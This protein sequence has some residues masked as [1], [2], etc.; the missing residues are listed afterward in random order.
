M[1]FHQVPVNAHG[2]AWHLGLTLVLLAS[3]TQQ[4][5]VTFKATEA[6]GQLI[7]GS[8][9]P[10]THFLVNLFGYHWLRLHG[11]ARRGAEGRGGG[12]REKWEGGAMERQPQRVR[13]SW[14][15]KEDDREG[16]ERKRRR[17]K[18]SGGGGE[19]ETQKRSCVS[20]TLSWT[21]WVLGCLPLPTPKAARTIIACVLSL[22]PQ[23]S[24]L[25]GS[26]SVTTIIC[27]G[28]PSC[29]GWVA[30]GY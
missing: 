2:A 15:R 12:G 3:C 18:E 23:H 24:L 5:T 19:K 14:R 21:E 27:A 10:S 13:T 8:V 16:R 11:G 20:W 28:T 30:L 26:P 1:N 9:L 25:L 29:S 4:P 17:D 6:P 22:Q 7:P